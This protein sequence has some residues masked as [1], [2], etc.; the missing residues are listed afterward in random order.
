MHTEAH[1]CTFPA[2]LHCY[3]TLLCSHRARTDSYARMHADDV[4][5]CAALRAMQD[6]AEHATDK[7][8]LEEFAG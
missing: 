5:A 6:K 2:G 1:A 8:G 7:Q 3:S 4:H